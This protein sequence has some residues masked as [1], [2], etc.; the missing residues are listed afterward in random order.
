MKIMDVKTFLVGNPWKNWIFIKVYTD[1][2][3]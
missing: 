1:E 3:G 2:G